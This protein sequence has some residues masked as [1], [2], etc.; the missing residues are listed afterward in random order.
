MKTLLAL[1]FIAIY[2]YATSSIAEK[3]TQLQLTQK[4]S[5]WLLEHPRIIVGMDLDYAPYEWVD[6]QG[7]YK[8]IMVDYLHG[9]EQKL[10]VHFEIV[11][12][13]TWEEL[14]TLAKQ[15]ELNMLTSIVKTPERSKYLSFSEPYHDAPI[16]I[17][18]NGKGN[19]IGT[20][21]QLSKK[22]VVVEKDY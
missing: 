6:E 9:I 14:L 5:Q 11:K 3:S 10:G 12:N 20:L 2:S 21:K 16:I 15:G 18:D 1:F 8:G 7:N 17:V 22:R 13:K 19:F 4:Q